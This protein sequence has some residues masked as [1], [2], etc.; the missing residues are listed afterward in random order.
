MSTLHDIDPQSGDPVS[1]DA[2]DLV[3][4]PRAHDIGD[5]FMV[6]RALPSAGKRM[7][8]PFI[9]LD[10]MGPALLAPGKGID[11]RPH[12]HIGL[13][14][15]TYLYEGEIMH[16]DSLGSALPIRPGEL[17]WMT[18]GSGIAHSERSGNDWRAH[19][20]A[21]SGLQLWV[22]L[23]GA[24]E[25][26]APG[27]DHYDAAALPIVQDKGVTARI[28]AGAAL[29]A[30]SPVQ[31]FSDTIFVDFDLAAGASAPIDAAHEERALY[32]FSGTVEIGPDAFE[33]GRLIILKP[34]VGISV[35]A[36]TPAR[37]ALV[38]GETADGP[39][40]IW[41]NFVSARK[42]RIEQAK[43]DWAAGRF[44]QVPGEAE[45]IPLP[46]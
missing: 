30:R 2:V 20:G 11:V 46:E 41:W 23:P 32:I 17:N 25:E 26:T 3:V 45:F 21:L 28:I 37:F 6:R 9:F 7:I 1:C 33:A 38:G 18:A 35:K 10:Q 42:E 12:P 14:T 44:A 24:Y 29:G 8:G 39:R 36:A 27:F 34:G 22:A 4:V 13:A 40:Y 15:V 43:A 19:G 5:G 16:R 31:T